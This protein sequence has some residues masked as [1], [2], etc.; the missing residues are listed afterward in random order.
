MVLIDQFIE[1]PRD[2]N[3]AR[4]SGGSPG[5]VAPRG[6]PTSAVAQLFSGTGTDAGGCSN[7]DAPACPAREWDRRRVAAAGNRGGGT[8]MP[9][10]IRS[11]PPVLRGWND[12]GAEDRQERH[13]CGLHPAMVHGRRQ[14]I[15][16]EPDPVEIATRLPPPRTV[17]SSRFRRRLPSTSIGWDVSIDPEPVRAE[18]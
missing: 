14:R 10:L 8:E 7:H 15:R 18:R 3:A 17:P 13:R 2:K 11:R 9:G 1:G 16:I 4:S 5:E 6:C 12:G